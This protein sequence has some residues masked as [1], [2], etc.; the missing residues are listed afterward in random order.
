M[1]KKK[2]ISS[3]SKSTNTKPKTKTVVV[4]A[5]KVVV[6]APIVSNNSKLSVKFKKF[7]FKKF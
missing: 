6:E 4:E 2:A 5:E 1:A 3:K 7:S